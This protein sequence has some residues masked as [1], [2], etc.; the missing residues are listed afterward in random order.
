MQQLSKVWTKSGKSLMYNYSHLVQRMPKEQRK[1]ESSIKE[2]DTLWTFNLTSARWSLSFPSLWS[3]PRLLLL[4]LG[5]LSCPWFPS[6]WLPSGRC[7]RSR[8][9]LWVLGAFWPMLPVARYW[10]TFF[11]ARLSDPE[12]YNSG[13]VTSSQRANAKPKPDSQS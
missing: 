3:P 2:N 4:A 8:W 13:F 9:S 10:L 12:E 1:K 5:N 11:S 6:W 7:S